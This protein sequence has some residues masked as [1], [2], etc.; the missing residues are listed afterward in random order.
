[1]LVSSLRGQSTIDLRAIAAISDISGDERRGQVATVT[2][3]LTWWRS[4]CAFWRG[5]RSVAIPWPIVLAAAA[6]TAVLGLAIWNYMSEM[7]VQYTW[8]GR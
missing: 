8:T 5:E 1:V 3:P 7:P 6:A 4:W 2:W